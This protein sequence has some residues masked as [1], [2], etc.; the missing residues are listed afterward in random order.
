MALSVK[1][2]I[3]INVMITS[4]TP[5]NAL[6][7]TQLI[8]IQ[9]KLKKL[10]YYRDNIDGI[11][12]KNTANAFAQWK[13]DNYLSEPQLIGVSS[14]KQLTN[15]ANG[16][17]VTADPLAQ[18]IVKICDER[19][20][21]LL[22]NGEINIVGLEGVNVDG[23]PNNDAPNHWNDAIGILSFV[24]GAPTLLCIYQGTT[25]PG[26]FYTVN[27]LN[28]NGAARLQLGHHKRLWVV[29]RHRGY[30]ALAQA[31]SVTLV[32]DKNRNH[33]R[34]DVVTVESG[35][36]INLHGTSPNFIPN[37]VD[38]FSAGCVVIRRWREFQQFMKLV[39]QSKQYRENRA[40]RFD[41]ILLWRDWLV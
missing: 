9:T 14:Y 31:G 17:K 28:R 35:N 18:K 7:K 41:F 4:T 24:N 1:I 15:D 38:R 32:R 29:G 19:K 8:D 10:S 25:E 11:F 3:N 21:P 16:V 20:Y 27:P 2:K 39:K 13:R 30:E 37:L 36:G 6:N 40:Y 33:M 12:G 22:R 26:H 23:T 5:V 34:D